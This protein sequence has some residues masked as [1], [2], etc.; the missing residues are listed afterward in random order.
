MISDI[1]TQ[2]SG[3]DLPA[4]VR[5]EKYDIQTIFLTTMLISLCPKAIE[6]QSFEYYSNW[7]TPTA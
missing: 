4:W 7:L 1:E 5:S 6:L 2:G 3:P